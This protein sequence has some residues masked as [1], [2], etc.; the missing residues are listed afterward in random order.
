MTNSSPLHKWKVENS[1]FCGH[2]CHL[3]EI[4]FFSDASAHTNAQ[5][6]LFITNRIKFRFSNGCI[7]NLGTDGYWVRTV[8]QV[9]TL[10]VASVCWSNR[11]ADNVNNNKKSPLTAFAL[12]NH[13]HSLASLKVD[14]WVLLPLIV[15]YSHVL[16]QHHRLWAFDPWGEETRRQPP[17][18]CG[19]TWTTPTAH[20][21]VS[22]VC[23]VGCHRL[24]PDQSEGKLMPWLHCPNWP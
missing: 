20:Y 5:Q 9:K 23:P 21:V 8:L 13:I 7:S 1:R 18:C 19:S 17:A 14:L 6:N 4:S 24:T 11:M 3:T 22:A 15:G 12:L 10:T 2:I 16:L